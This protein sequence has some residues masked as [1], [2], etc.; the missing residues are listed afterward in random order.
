MK[1]HNKSAFTLAEVLITLGIIGVVAVL[2][3]TTLIKN[4]EE[5]QTAEQIRSVKYKF[6]KATENMN[7]LGL[8]TTAYPSTADFVNELKKHLKIIKICN[9]DK[10]DGCWPY[11]KINMPDG[12]KL[13][14]SNIVDG[15]SFKK[16]QGDWSSPVMGI[17][18]A[19]GTP[20]IFTYKKDC[21]G[22]NPNIQYAW[23]FEDGKP[24][25]NATTSCIAG[26]FDINGKSGYNQPNKDV[27]SFG[28][29]GIG[30]DCYNINVNGVC[31]NDPII[32]EPK[33]D[34]EGISSGCSSGSPYYNGAIAICEGEENLPSREELLELVSQIVVDN[35]FDP[36]LAK[37]KGIFLEPPFSII[38]S[39]SPHPNNKFKIT[40]NTYNPKY[41]ERTV[42][43]SYS[44]ITSPAYVMCK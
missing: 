39:G 35:K 2:S 20:M 13:K 9:S 32:P 18:T 44:P 6:T 27:I 37:K 40:I 16:H 12:S 43:S 19:D 42:G 33:N 24:V 8:M 15:A 30:S 3:I 36:E 38:A 31:F 5:K 34:C 21:A 29:N 23:T 10:L 11:D 26:I 14:I 25:T 17:I 22:F 1:K 7:A 28:A 4:I 41:P